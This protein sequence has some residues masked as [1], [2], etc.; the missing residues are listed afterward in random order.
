M[1]YMKITCH[2]CGGKW[3]VYPQTINGGRTCPHCSKTI[4]RQ[5]WEKQVVPAF[6]ALDDANRELVKDH[7]GYHTTLFEISYKA[8]S[9]FQ[10]NGTI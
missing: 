8:D 4:D 9:V 5:T 3:E 2:H 10:N 7:T 6:H 1:G